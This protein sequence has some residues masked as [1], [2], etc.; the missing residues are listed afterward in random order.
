M[1]AY[2]MTTG[3]VFGLLV[4]AHIWRFIVEGPDLARNPAY[5]LT[6]LAGV[7]LCVWACYLLMR[8]SR[9]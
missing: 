9:S 6:T 7:S 8:R 4:A 3:T 2:V 5:V 1:K